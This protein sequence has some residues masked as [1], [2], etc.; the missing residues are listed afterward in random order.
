MKT[1]YFIIGGATLILLTM[2]IMMIYGTKSITNLNTTIDYDSIQDVELTVNNWQYIV[3]PSIIKLGV[4][5][6]MTVDLS[7]VVG[8]A[9][10]IVIPAFNTR[11]YVS[12]VNDNIIYFMPDHAGNFSIVCSM[13]MY[14]GMFEVR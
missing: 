1:K 11:K 10:D 9:R 5:V 13:I 3:T 8:C 7:K 14:K 6:K 12:G 2:F 4:P